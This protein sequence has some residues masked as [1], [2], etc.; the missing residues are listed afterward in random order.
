MTTKHKKFLRIIIPTLIILIV[1]GIWFSKNKSSVE[2]ITDNPDF[3][4]ET[5]SIDL[6]KLKTY[7]LPIII[8][9]GSDSCIPCLEMAPVLE[10]YNKEKIGE[11]IIKFV[12]VWKNQH[13]AD[14][15]PIQV[16]PTQVFYTADGK[17]YVPSEEIQENIPFTLYSDKETNEHLFT[18][19]QGGLTNEQMELIISELEEN[20]E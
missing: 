6:D 10:K 18:I 19:H 1:G 12:D 13:G 14:G 3:V 9:F 17:P 11:V 7:E 5:D 4:L 8:D 20:N 16:I 15:F 2:E